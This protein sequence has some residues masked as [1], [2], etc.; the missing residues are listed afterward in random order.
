MA[1]VFLGAAIGAEVVGTLCLR[2]SD[3]LSR[4]PFVAV[5]IAGYVAAFVLLS[6]AL[7]RGLA[8]GVA[9]GIWAAA[10]VGAVAVLSVPLFGESLS[11]LQ[12]G[13]LVLVVLGVFALELGATG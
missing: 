10:G 12:V 13:G 1:Y 2:A 6:L 7:D 8:L 5:V 9:Y 3:G 4:P 11:A